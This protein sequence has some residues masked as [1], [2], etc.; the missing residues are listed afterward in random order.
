MSASLAFLSKTPAHK[1]KPARARGITPC[2]RYGNRAKKRRHSI[3][4]EIEG[5]HFAHHLEKVLDDADLRLLAGFFLL[6]DEWD[7]LQST[8]TSVDSS[9]SGR[10]AA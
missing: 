3:S 2:G 8:Q 10:E 5:T 4:G 6:L 1:R 7:T 9:S